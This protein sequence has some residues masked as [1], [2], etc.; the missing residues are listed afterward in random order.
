MSMIDVYIDTE[1]DK[2][3][4]DQHLMSIKTDGEH[5][6]DIDIEDGKIVTSGFIGYNEYDD[7]VELILGLQGHGISIDDFYF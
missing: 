2:N 3:M 6:G 7:F 5:I 1:G 4:K